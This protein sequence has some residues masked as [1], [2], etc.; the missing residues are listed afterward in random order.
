MA[1]GLVPILVDDECKDIDKYLSTNKIYNVKIILGIQ[2]DSD[3]PL[4]LI[5]KVN[6]IENFEDFFREYK[7]NFIIKNYKFDQKYHYFST[8]AMS[9][10]KHS[11]LD[12]SFHSVEIIKSDIITTGFINY[13]D[14]KE[15]IITTINKI[16][17]TKNFRQHQIIDQWNKIVLDKLPFIDLELHVSSGFF[18]RQFI[19]DLSI[20]LK[21]PMLAFDIYRKSI[22]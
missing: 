18:V 5:E 7:D 6:L 9:M 17:K 14:W 8:K 19:R 20:K 21:Q 13:N 1:R 11:K 16:D 10:R 4:G 15:E 3:D 2:T 22:L 12:D